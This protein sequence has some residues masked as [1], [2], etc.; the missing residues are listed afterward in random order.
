M[1]S[2]TSGRAFR[3]V[4]SVGASIMLTFCQ[5]HLNRHLSPFMPASGDEL[6]GRVSFAAS[7]DDIRRLDKDRYPLMVQRLLLIPRVRS[8]G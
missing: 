2:W 7:V 3:K 4:L 8:T 1:A 6:A 5:I